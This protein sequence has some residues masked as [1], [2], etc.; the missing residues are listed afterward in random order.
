[1][2]ASDVATNMEPQIA[3]A[4]G[5]VLGNGTATKGASDEQSF[6]GDYLERGVAPRRD[7]ALL[8]PEPA[9]AGRLVAAG[10][11]VRALVRA[12]RLDRGVG[13]RDEGADRDEALATSRDLNLRG[14]ELAVSARLDEGG[15]AGR[16]PV[17][18]S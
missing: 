7:V 14:G 12:R 2:L 13:R 3:S 8:R 4:T 15:G 9:E 5:A 17:N 6:F 18:Y 11:F 1:V 16:A 10:R